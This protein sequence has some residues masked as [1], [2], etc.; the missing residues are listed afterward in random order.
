MP[1]LTPNA[2][3]RRLRNQVAN[4]E[5][6]KRVLE[7]RLGDALQEIAELRARLLAGKPMLQTAESGLQRIGDVDAITAAQL[8]ATIEVLRTAL[9][10]MSEKS[11]E[12]E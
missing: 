5:D 3:L 6:D 10:L 9:G 8:S 2:E 4:L 11:D 1:E 12:E 7:Q